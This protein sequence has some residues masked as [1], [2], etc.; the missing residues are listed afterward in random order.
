MRTLAWKLNANGLTTQSFAPLL[1]CWRYTRLSPFGLTTFT[2][3]ESSNQ[4]RLL[5]IQR[6]FSLSATPLRQSAEK[7][8]GIKFLSCPGRA[9]T[10]WKFRA[11]SGIAWRSRSHMLRRI[12]QRRAEDVR[13]ITLVCKRPLVFF[14]TRTSFEFT[15]RRQ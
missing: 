1:H 15:G 9:E 6:P 11:T 4:E 5:G 14:S 2:N 7:S 3:S 8:G 10:P 13:T 12:G